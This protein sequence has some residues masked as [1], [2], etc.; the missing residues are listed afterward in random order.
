MHSLSPEMWERLAGLRSRGRLRRRVPRR[1]GQRAGLPG[2]RRRPAGPPA[3]G[4]GMEGH[5]PRPRRRG[6]AHRPAGRPR[7]PG[8]LQVPLEHPLQRLPDQRLRLAALRRAGPGRSARLGPPAAATGTPRWHR[9][10]TRRSTRPSVCAARRVEGVAPSPRVALAIG[11]RRPARSDRLARPRPSRC[12]ASAA[13]DGGGE[14]PTAGPTSEQRRA[15]PGARTTCRP[16]P[17]I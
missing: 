2:R 16:A 3:P 5:G 11:A 1:L 17:S 6:G 15:A 12:R 10:S 4:R 8:Q 13:A 14:C 7:L 9:P